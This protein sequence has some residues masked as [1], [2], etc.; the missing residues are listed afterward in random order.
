MN[1]GWFCPLAITWPLLLMLCGC[2]AA[3]A[4]AVSRKPGIVTARTR[5]R[6]LNNSRSL[7]LPSPV[8]ALQRQVSSLLYLISPTG[9]NNKQPQSVTGAWLPGTSGPKAATRS[10]E[11]VQRER[12]GL[13]GRQLP[14]LLPR[15]G[16]VGLVERGADDSERRLVLPFE[17]R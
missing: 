2:A 10:P 11:R 1:A 9:S 8:D 12:D 14:A 13:V 6:Y 17:V 7:S 3:G 15:L 4:T 16:E 5:T